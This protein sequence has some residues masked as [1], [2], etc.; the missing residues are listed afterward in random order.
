MPKKTTQAHR[1]DAIKHAAGSPGDSFV[2]TILDSVADGVFTVDPE[3]RITSFNKAAERILG[4]SP[5]KALGQACREVFRADI[6]QADCALRESIANGPAEWEE[7]VVLAH[8]RLSRIGR[9]DPETGRAA[10]Q[11]EVAHKLFHMAL[12]SA[13]RSGFLIRYCEQLYDLNIRYR[14]IAGT[15]A[16]PSRNVVE[17][18]R[19]ICDATVDRDAAG[20]VELLVDHYNRT[21]SFLSLRLKEM[22]A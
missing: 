11:W 21:G 17:E 3:F 12:I 18:H 19:A 5:D 16:Y 15:A 6:C 2:R 13:C 8:H 9:T 20:A 1:K 10:P 4:L 22:A 7:N 14:N